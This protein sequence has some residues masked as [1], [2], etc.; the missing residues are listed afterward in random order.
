MLSAWRAAPALDFGA[1]ADCQS[2]PSLTGRIGSVFAR[3]PRKQRKQAV[4]A[5]RGRRHEVALAHPRVGV[6]IEALRVRDELPRKEIAGR[7]VE[8]NDREVGLFD[9]TPEGLYTDPNRKIAELPIARLT[10]RE[11]A[12]DR[13]GPRGTLDVE[14]DVDIELAA[15]EPTPTPRLVGGFT[16]FETEGCARDGEPPGHGRCRELSAT[17]H[18]RARVRATVLSHVDLGHRKPVFPRESS[19]R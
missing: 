1:R 12:I 3:P 15:G 10:A 11:R 18:H 7:P 2:A 5:G 14:V 4:V 6:R 13:D 17:N 8:R 9:D 19:V 16:A